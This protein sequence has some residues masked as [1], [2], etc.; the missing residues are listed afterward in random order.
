MTDGN[1]TQGPALTQRRYNGICRPDGAG[2]VFG[3]LFSTKISLLTELSQSLPRIGVAA[4]R[5]RA[6]TSILRRMRRPADHRY[7]AGKRQTHHS[8]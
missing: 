6:A 4:P 1:R 2:I 8:M 7:V 5:Q 3:G